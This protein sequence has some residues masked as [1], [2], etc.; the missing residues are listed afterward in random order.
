MHINSGYWK[1]E[2]IPAA[3]NIEI[4][5]IF[6]KFSQKKV[7]VLERDIMFAMFSVR[8]L[9]E[10]HKLSEE[11]LSST[12]AVAAYPKKTSKP[13]TWLN[14]HKI[15]ELYDLTQQ[16]EQSLSLLFLCNQIIHS[17]IL[18]PVQEN[19]RFTDILVCSDY[20]R[21]NF[22][23]MVPIPS[24]VFLL[25][26]VASDDPSRMEMSFNPRRKDYDIKNYR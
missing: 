14:N 6:S 22:L 10:R 13:V 17:Y 23:Y 26:Q 5:S 7:D 18:L 15:A 16:V 9:I 11:V 4:K 25:R 12:H 8:T 19:Q 20:E 2:L 21:N 3:D 24:I 1:S